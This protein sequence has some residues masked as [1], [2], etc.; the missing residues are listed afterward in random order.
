MRA[1]FTKDGSQLIVVVAPS[2]RTRPRRSRRSDHDPR[3][4]HARTD[5]SPD[6]AGSLR[7]RVRRVWYCVTALRAHA[8]RPL[9]ASPRPRKASW[10]WWDLR[11]RRKTRALE[12]ESRPRTRSL[13]ARTV[14][15][16]RS[17]SSDGI[18]LVD[19]RSG[20]VRTAAGDPAG[21]PSWVLFSPDGKMVVATNR[22]GTVTAGTSRRRHRSRRCAATRTTCSSRS[23]APTGRRSTP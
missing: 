11:S 15:P 10:R 8:R 7:R 13:S 12:I 19:V 2:P 4:R 5:R 1:A 6:R 18:Q 3:R 22:D 17:A 9:S 14:S 23:S 20:T 21:N 16:W